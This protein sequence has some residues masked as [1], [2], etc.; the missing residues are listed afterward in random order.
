VESDPALVNEIAAADD[1]T[2]YVMSA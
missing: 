1:E 2:D